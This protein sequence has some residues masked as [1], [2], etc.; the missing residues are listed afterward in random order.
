MCCGLCMRCGMCVVVAHYGVLVCRMLC[1]VV[2]LCIVAC[3]C[4][5]LCVVARRRVFVWVVVR[6]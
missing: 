2:L 6:C 5:S 1:G 4:V 3:W